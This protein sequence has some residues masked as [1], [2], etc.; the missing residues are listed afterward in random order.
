M[1]VGLFELARVA[2]NG[3]ASGEVVGTAGETA[4]FWLTGGFMSPADTCG[5]CASMEN[6]ADRFALMLLS[7]AVATVGACDVLIFCMLKD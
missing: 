3:D 2:G 5:R 6:A 7:K 1:A 4:V